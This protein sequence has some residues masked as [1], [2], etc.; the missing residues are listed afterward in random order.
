MV[1]S[2]YLAMDRLWVHT[3]SP[4]SLRRYDI[5]DRDGRFAGSVATSLDIVS[6]LRPVVRGDRFY[7]VVTGKLDIPYVVRARMAEPLR[8]ER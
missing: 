6:W 2:A 8:D 3:S 5:Y 7:A 4:D 1:R